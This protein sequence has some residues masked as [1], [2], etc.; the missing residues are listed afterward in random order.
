M[1][2]QVRVTPNP[3]DQ[4]TPYELRVEPGANYRTSYRVP[5]DRLVTLEVKDGLVTLTIDAPIAP[6]APAQTTTGDN[7]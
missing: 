7:P 4:P 2:I 3:T 5:A 1:A 6:P